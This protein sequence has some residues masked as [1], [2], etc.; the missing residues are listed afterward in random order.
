M[1]W[2]IQVAARAYSS[3][4]GGKKSHSV[5]KEAVAPLLEKETSRQMFFFLLFYYYFV[6]LIHTG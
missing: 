3:L 1:E 5:G 2:R 6:S 4:E